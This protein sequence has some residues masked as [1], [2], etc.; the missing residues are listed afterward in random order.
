[1]IFFVFGVS[2]GAGCM[3]ECVWA[4]GGS[5]SIRSTQQ[6]DPR[7]LRHTRAAFANRLC[8]KYIPGESPH[9]EKTAEDH[10]NRVA[11]VT[12]VSVLSIVVIFVIVK[13][14]R[15]CACHEQ[16]RNAC[17][18]G[19]CKRC[20]LRQTRRRRMNNNRLTFIFPR[21]VSDKFNACLILSSLFS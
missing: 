8:V 19:V 12:P 16:Q 3:R 18:W 17:T 13:R 2:L 10:K 20:H 4:L 5:A 6:R 11:A 7:L 14:G 15:A 1:M 21:M 9:C